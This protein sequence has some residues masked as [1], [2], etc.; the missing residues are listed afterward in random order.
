MPVMDGYSATVRIRSREASKGVRR[1][2]VVALTANA[3]AEDMARAHIAGMDAH[4]AKP[5]H[6]LP[7]R[8]MLST[9]L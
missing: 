4:L 9:W 3:S 7:I 1:V 6:V 2:P 8:E 5:E